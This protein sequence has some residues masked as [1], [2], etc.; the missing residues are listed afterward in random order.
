MK[1][2]LGGEGWGEKIGGEGGEGGEKISRRGGVGRK[3]RGGGG[4]KK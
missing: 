2:E 1:K 4:A 3:N